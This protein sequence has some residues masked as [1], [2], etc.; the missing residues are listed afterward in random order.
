MCFQATKAKTFSLSGQLQ[1]R[2]TRKGSEQ[3][4]RSTAYMASSSLPSTSSGRELKMKSIVTHTF[5]GN[6]NNNNINNNNNNN[7]LHQSAGGEPEMKFLDTHQ[8]KIRFIGT[9]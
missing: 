8:L 7:N 6:N 4:V 1:R 3:D 9:L 5:V 2:E